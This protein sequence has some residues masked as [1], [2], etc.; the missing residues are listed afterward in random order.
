MPGNV[1]IDILLFMTIKSV[2]MTVLQR[3]ML[4]CS[5]EIAFIGIAPS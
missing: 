3:M 1:T 2:F 4:T 5:P